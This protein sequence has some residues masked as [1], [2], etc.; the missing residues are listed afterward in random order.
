LVRKSFAIK[1]GRYFGATGWGK[2]GPYAVA[3]YRRG[4]A[5]GKISFGTKGGTVGG[6][7]RVY[8]KVRFGGEYNLT[9]HSSAIEMR[10]KRRTFSLDTSLLAKLRKL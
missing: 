3:T 9:H 6:R 1:K 5:L 2:Y 10:N 4:R 7:V 8:K